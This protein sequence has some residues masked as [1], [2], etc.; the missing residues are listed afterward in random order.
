MAP[1]D[2]EKERKAKMNA[3]ITD[4]KSGDEKKISKALKGLQV[5]G[6]ND[7]IFPIIEVWSQGVSPKSE[8]DI[9]Q[10]LGDIKSSGSADI[11]IEVLLD[12]T[13]K[14][15]HLT[16]LTTICNSKVDYSTYLVDFVTLATQYD[17]MVTLECLT[18]IENLDGPFE[19]HHF[20]DAEIILREFAE[21][22]Q[23]GKLEE[24]K[25]LQLIGELK[26]VLKDLES[27]NIEI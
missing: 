9:I 3:L 19:E 22:N 10:F 15:I 16:L 14:N 26:H 13:F 20:L 24:D 23:N 27:R 2:E 21:K 1:R 17:F 8:Q 6:D 4:L 5:N 11:I 25:K 18:I 12:Q 7:A